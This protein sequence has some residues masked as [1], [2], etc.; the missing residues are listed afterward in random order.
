MTAVLNCTAVKT[1]RCA[2]IA[3]VCHDVNR[4][5]SSLRCF[6]PSV[7]EL[8]VS[9]SS[10][11]SSHYSFRLFD[12]SH[13]RFHPNPL[14]FIST[15]NLFLRW[16]TDSPTDSV[17]K[18]LHFRSHLVLRGTQSFTTVHP[19]ACYWTLSYAT[20]WIKSTPSRFLK[21]ILTSS[22]HLQKVLPRTSHK[23][24]EGE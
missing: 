11:S 5:M 1:S 7:H 12:S 20:T 17:V 8:P 6:Y 23:G 21:S 2:F 10:Y 22:S 4:R 14:Q 13:G 16:T 19:A 24:P 3:T 9:R 15:N 18:S